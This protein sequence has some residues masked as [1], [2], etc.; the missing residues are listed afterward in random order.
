VRVRVR[1][2]RARYAGAAARPAAG[3]H[4]QTALPRQGRGGQGVLQ[5]EHH[6]DGEALAGRRRV[7]GPRRSPA[8][9]V[10][11]RGQVKSR[12][13]PSTGKQEHESWRALVRDS[14]GSNDKLPLLH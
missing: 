3:V 4:G 10:V 11:Q 12:P 9:V 14:N 5:R 8:F 2:G 1:Q 13:V 6:R 7:P